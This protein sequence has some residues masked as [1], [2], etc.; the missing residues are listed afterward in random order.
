MFKHQYI[1][2]WIDILTGFIATDCVN[3][4]DSSLD[5][6]ELNLTNSQA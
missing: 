3:A 1:T 6:L 4:K 5:H 2:A